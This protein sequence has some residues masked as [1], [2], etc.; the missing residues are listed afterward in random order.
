MHAKV[1]FVLL[2]SAIAALNAA[3]GFLIVQFSPKSDYALYTLVFSFLAVFMNISNIGITPAMSGIGGR[4]WQDPAALRA[5]LNSA[6][7]LRSR[8]GVWLLLPFS[9]Y[10]AW[11]FWQTGDSLKEWGMGGDGYLGYLGENRQNLR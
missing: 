4:V 5:L 9:A 1:L 11:Q 10:C 7:H 8:I 2:Q 3:A 6:F